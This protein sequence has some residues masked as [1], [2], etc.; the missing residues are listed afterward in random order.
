MTLD[1]VRTMVAWVHR[2]PRETGASRADT[3]RSVRAVFCRPSIL[4]DAALRRLPDG[5]RLTTGHLTLG[6]GLDASELFAR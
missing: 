1:S 2:P 6:V 3:V 4:P 5:L